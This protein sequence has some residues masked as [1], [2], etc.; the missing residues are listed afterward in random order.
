VVLS[1]LVMHVRVAGVI[2]YMMAVGTQPFQ[3]YSD[4]STVFKIL[5]VS[6]SL[7]SHA[8]EPCASV[9]KRM[10]VRYGAGEA[11]A[12][13]RRGSYTCTSYTARSHNAR[14]QQS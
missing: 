7:P 12:G 10:L 4:H 13:F 3:T 6:Y 9:L 8:T 2:L 14:P 11:C 5:D 1:F